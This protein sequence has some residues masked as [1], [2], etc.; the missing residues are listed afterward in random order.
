MKIPELYF[1]ELC[2]L[3]KEQ[4]DAVLAAEAELANA[5]FSGKR[6]EILCAILNTP[7]ENDFMPTTFKAKY[8]KANYRKNEPNT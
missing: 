1:G 2:G 5:G 3:T 7:R 6:D 8:L 4:S